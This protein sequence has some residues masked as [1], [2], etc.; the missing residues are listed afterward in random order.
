MQV[1]EINDVAPQG[2]VYQLHRESTVGRVF[3]NPNVVEVVVRYSNGSERT[4]RR[5]EES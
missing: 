4:F 5:E 1:R 2:V 3:V